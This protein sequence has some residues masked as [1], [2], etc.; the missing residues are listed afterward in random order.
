MFA[1]AFVG[2]ADTA[3]ADRDG[4][5]EPV[6]NRDLV[7][8]YTKA[9]RAAGVGPRQL[10]RWLWWFTSGRRSEYRPQIEFNHSDA[11]SLCDRLAFETNVECVVYSDAFEL[12][13]ASLGS[14]WM[15]ASQFLR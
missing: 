6:I 14:A 11:T 9:L 8:R 4:E 10:K 12:P 3:V 1:N 5:L 2:D 13:G 7:I 15:P